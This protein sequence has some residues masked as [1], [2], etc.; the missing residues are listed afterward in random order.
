M[1]KNNIWGKRSLPGEFLAFLHRKGLG[2]VCLC[3]SNLNFL[4]SIFSAFPIIILIK[5]K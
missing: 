2:E 3:L 1:Q 5:F 4:D